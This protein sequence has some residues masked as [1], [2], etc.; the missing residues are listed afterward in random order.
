MRF[1][2]IKQDSSAR[3]AL[4]SSTKSVDLASSSSISKPK[5]E[6]TKPQKTILTNN[7]L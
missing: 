4:L 5:F 2:Y 3:K 7:N 6:R 1:K